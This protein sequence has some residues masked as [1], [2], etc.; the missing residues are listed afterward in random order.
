MP[1]SS[2]VGPSGRS[3]A[4]GAGLPGGT[5]TRPTSSPLTTID[6]SARPAGVSRTGLRGT[7]CLAFMA[8]SRARV[9]RKSPTGALGR[10]EMVRPSFMTTTNG[11]T[12][13]PYSLATYAPRST[14]GSDSSLFRMSD[15]MSSARRPPDAAGNAPAVRLASQTN[16]S[17][18]VTSRTPRNATNPS[19]TRQYRLRY[20]TGLFD[21]CCFVTRAPHGQDDRGV[22]RFVFDLAPQ[23]FDERIH[24]PNGDERFIRPGPAQERLAAQHDP[25]LRQQDVEQIELLVCQLDIAPADAYTTTSGIHFDVAEGNRLLSAVELGRTACA[26]APHHGAYTRKQLTDP[27]RFHHIVVGPAAQ[28]PH[29]VRLVAARGEHE[30]RHVAV[31]DVAPYRPADRQPINPRQH[32]VEHDEIERLSSC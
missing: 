14:S 10:L 15:A 9:F 8:A 5:A 13:R 12:T 16:S 30:D 23:P 28:S 4:I 2:S 19:P 25:R 27:D 24:A 32:Q 20:Q 29:L 1:D 31:R 18:C 26:A 3:A 17:A 7:N 11:C 22:R 6:A 21:I